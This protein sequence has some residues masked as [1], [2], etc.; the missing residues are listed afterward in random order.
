MHKRLP[1]VHDVTFAS[2]PGVLFYPY[3]HPSWLHSC[4]FGWALPWQSIAG[5]AH[6]HDFRCH[7]FARPLASASA[8]LKQCKFAAC[9]G[10][11]S[12]HSLPCLQGMRNATCEWLAGEA[13]SCALTMQA[14]CFHL[15]AIVDDPCSWVQALRMASRCWTQGYCLVW[16]RCPKLVG[17]TPFHFPDRLHNTTRLT[18]FFEK[19]EQGLEENTLRRQLM[20]A[21]QTD[22]LP[23]LTSNKEP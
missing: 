8:I 22:K 4:V 6:T 7:V 13:Q 20:Q 12:W 23:N 15:R 9:N 16:K 3:F 21:L 14:P 11:M 10:N 2:P 17:C 5:T 1:Q 18:F 19:Y